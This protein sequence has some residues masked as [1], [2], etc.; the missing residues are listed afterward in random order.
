MFTSS[1]EKKKRNFNVQQRDSFS[2]FSP[3][4]KAGIELFSILTP[5]EILSNNSS[6]NSLDQ[7]ENFLRDVFSSPNLLNDEEERKNQIILD[8]L[9]PPLRSDNP[10]ESDHRFSFENFEDEFE[11]RASIGAELGLLTVSPTISSH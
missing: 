10:I 4:K 1:S 7:Q 8:T 11:E 9:T 6:T 5:T 3:E 2:G